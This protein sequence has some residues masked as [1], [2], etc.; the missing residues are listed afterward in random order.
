MGKEKGA[1]MSTDQNKTV[2]RRIVDEAWNKHN[3]AILDQLFSN[4]AV[5]HDPQNPTITKGPQGAKSTLAI[6]LRAFPDMK[7]SI[8]REIADG[9]YVVQHL[10]ATGTNT[11]EFNGMPATGKKTNTIGVMTS[12]IKDGKVVEAW[13]LFDSLGLM[14]Q[15]GVIPAPKGASTPERELVGAR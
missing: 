3:P 9:D 13:S 15:L 11:G 4:D 8:E 2:A 14:Q 7:I 10:L 5:V 1:I 12:K 6:Y